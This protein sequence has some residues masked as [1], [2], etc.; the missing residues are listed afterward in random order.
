MAICLQLEPR[1]D[2][3]GMAKRQNNSNIGNNNS[4]R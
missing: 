3:N 4:T 2:K 1:Q